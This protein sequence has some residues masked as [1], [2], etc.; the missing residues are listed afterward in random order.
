M[1]FHYSD[2]WSN[3]NEKSAK[4]VKNFKGFDNMKK[5]YLTSEVATE[6]VSKKTIVRVPKEAK[7]PPNKKTIPKEE[8][9]VA[10]ASAEAIVV[11]VGH[12]E[13]NDSQPKNPKP[14]QAK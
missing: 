3:L 2:T 5:T 9:K 1:L 10:D 13:K 11:K 12:N 6:T 14:S 7:L 4:V 8:V